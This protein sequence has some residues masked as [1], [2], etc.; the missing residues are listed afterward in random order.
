MD[1]EL[2]PLAGNVVKIKEHKLHLGIPTSYGAGTHIS[3]NQKQRVSVGDEVEFTIQGFEEYQDGG[4]YW[5]VMV[6]SLEPKGHYQPTMWP[7]HH[8]SI[9]QR[10]FY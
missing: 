6:V 10:R 2:L 7:G 3:L 9:G 8:I 4:S 5:V 1:L